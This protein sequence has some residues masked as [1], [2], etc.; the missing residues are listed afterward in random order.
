MLG[1]APLILGGGLGIHSGSAYGTVPPDAAALV[2]LSLLISL[3]GAR[4][5]Y[6][7]VRERRRK[8]SARA[9]FRSEGL[10]SESCSVVEILLAALLLA[11]GGLGLVGHATTNA[12][13]ETSLELA[14][15][16]VG[17]L[18]LTTEVRR[19]RA[20]RHEPSRAAD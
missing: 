4:F 18:V 16:A 10:A 6:V 14:A 1:A 19:L 20:D 17:A 13:L 8:T 11:V 5:L 3:V 15:V 2:R 7:S 12:V 9:H